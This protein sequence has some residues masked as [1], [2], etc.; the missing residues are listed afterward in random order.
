MLIIL[1]YFEHLVCYLFRI[2]TFMLAAD[3]TLETMPN[4]MPTA[5]GWVRVEVKLNIPH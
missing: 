2:E 3:A 5:A 4:V 1:A